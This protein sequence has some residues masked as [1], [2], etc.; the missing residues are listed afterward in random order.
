MIEYREKTIF[1]NSKS[2]KLFN[3]SQRKNIKEFD[4]EFTFDIPSPFSISSQKISLTVPLKF[5]KNILYSN[6]SQYSSS[7]K[8]P[9]YWKKFNLKNKNPFIK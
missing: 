9:D 4:L 1:M 3:I 6:P 8:Q 2:F 5:E 7:G